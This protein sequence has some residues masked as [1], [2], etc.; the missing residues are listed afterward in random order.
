MEAVLISKGHGSRQIL[1]RVSQEDEAKG[2]LVKQGCSLG[3]KVEKEGLW[4]EEAS[5]RRTQRGCLLL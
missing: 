2:S 4:T 1:N 3:I 5:Q